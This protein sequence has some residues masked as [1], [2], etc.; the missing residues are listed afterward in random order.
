MKTYI[1]ICENGNCWEIIWAFP[2]SK[3]QFCGSNNFSTHTVNMK[4][5]LGWY[6]PYSEDNRS[7]GL[8]KDYK[9]CDHIIVRQPKWNIY[10]NECDN[11]WWFTHYPMIDDAEKMDILINSKI[12]KYWEYIP[13]INNVSVLLEYWYTLD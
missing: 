3:C 1:K 5:V 9:W 12:N 2:R 6:T 8:I 11:N 4:L 10:S 13:T 7:M